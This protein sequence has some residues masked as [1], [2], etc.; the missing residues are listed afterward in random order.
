LL[1]DTRPTRS[2]TKAAGAGVKSAKRLGSAV[3]QIGEAS[4]EG[5][6]GVSSVGQIGRAITEVVV[7]QQLWAGVDAGKSDHHCVVIDTDGQRLRSQRVANDET[8]LDEFIEEVTTLADGG[9][10]TWAMSF[11]GHTASWIMTSDRG[12]LPALDATEAGNGSWHAS[13]EAR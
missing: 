4:A 5:H 8:V 13:Q 6:V 3:R 10:V 9:A 7:A 1:V 2:P 11:G 12:W